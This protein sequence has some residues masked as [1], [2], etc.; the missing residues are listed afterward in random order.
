MRLPRSDA[1]DSVP[2]GD[3]VQPCDDDVSVLRSRL[4]GA[5]PADVNTQADQGDPQEQ[6][7]EA[8]YL[9]EGSDLDAEDVEREMAILP[10]VTPAATSVGIGD[11]HVGDSQHNTPEKIDRL[12]AIV[13]KRKR[14]LIGKGVGLPPPANGAICDIDVGNA[15]PVAQRVRKMPSQFYEKLYKLIKGLLAAGIIQPST[16]PWASP[17]V[18]IVKKNGVDIRL[19]IDYRVVNALTRLMVYPMPLV[20]DL[21]EDLDS[22]LWFCSLDMASG[23]WVVS[24]TER[25]RS[26][27][28]FIT[29]F[30]LF[31]WNRMPFGLKC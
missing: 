26:I 9:H 29:P 10:E 8:V 19:C 6:A 27:S 18:V 14:L 7:D 5:L 20:S 4:R 13:W 17:I 22:L 11:L 30:G 28:A 31:E 2:Q 16:S 1:S 21:L 3:A 25:A 15:K 12:R 24:M 23:F